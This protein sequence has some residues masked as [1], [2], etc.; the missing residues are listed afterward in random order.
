MEQFETYRPHI[1]IPSVIP[2]FLKIGYRDLLTYATIRSFLN[3]TT[4]KC[5]PEIR[6]IESKSGFSFTFISESIKRLETAGLIKVIT[7][8]RHIS[9]NYSFSDFDSFT[10]IPV[11]LLSVDEF[12]ASEKAFLI[13][14]RKFFDDGTMETILPLKDL[15]AFFDLDKKT[16]NKHFDSLL[17]KGYLGCIT[18]IKSVYEIELTDKF[19]W[20]ISDEMPAIIKNTEI[21]K[22][23]DRPILIIK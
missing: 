23:I 18:M 14:I 17:D 21:I 5:Y 6:T 13:C 19:D 10:R 20:R 11:S 2:S 7:G 1:L 15:T 8:K 3:S 9:N 16:I 12:S 4:K 22:D